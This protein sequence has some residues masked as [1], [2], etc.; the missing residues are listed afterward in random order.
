MSKS[1]PRSSK[2]RSRSPW[3]T[4]LQ[5]FPKGVEVQVRSPVAKLMQVEVDPIV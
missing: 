4:M 5:Y 2:A 1:F 3:R